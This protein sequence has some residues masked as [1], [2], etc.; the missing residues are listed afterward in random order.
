MAVENCNHNI[1]KVTIILIPFSGVYLFVKP[2]LTTVNQTFNDFLSYYYIF[3]FRVMLVMLV[4]LAP[5]E[6]LEER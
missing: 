3:N 1:S 6:M 5:K 2:A 4:L